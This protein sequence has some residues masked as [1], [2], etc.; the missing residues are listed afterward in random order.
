MILID[1][2]L[3]LPDNLGINSGIDPVARVLPVLAVDS[4]GSAL[5][6]LSDR[7]TQ[8]VKGQEYLAQVVSK[9][10]DKTYLVKV[11]NTV[12]KMELGTAAQAGQG[13]S[14]RY[15]QDSPVPTFFLNPSLPKIP[16]STAE[17]SSAATLIRQ[18]LKEAESTGVS[19]RHEV[20]AVVTHAPK[21]PQIIA[22]DLKQA[23]SNSGLFYES[24]LNEMMQGHRS[25]ASLMQ[26]PQNQSGAQVASLISH[27]LST[28][29]HQRISWH[30]EVWSG[31]KMDWDVYLQDQQPPEDDQQQTQPEESRPVASEITLHLPNL[32]KV[33]AKLNLAGG[34]MRIDILAE[35]APTLDMLKSQTRSLTQAITNNGLQLDALTVAHYD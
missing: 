23:I 8:F 11:E 33:T 27:Q 24:H 2:M 13:L 32:G 7:A 29:E 17:L 31:Q 34:R 1:T 16:E 22:Q 21:D 4:V 14:L 35:Q 28:L 19:G 15:M 5:Q 30:G 26:E 10:D 9:V 25:I 20:N 3:K 18:Y 12:L 6:E